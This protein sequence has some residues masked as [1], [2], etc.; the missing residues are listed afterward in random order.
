MSCSAIPEL[1]RRI[2]SGMDPKSVAGFSDIGQALIRGG[3]ATYAALGQCLSG[4]QKETGRYSA[5]RR[6]VL[7]APDP[8]S[9]GKMF[10]A[11]LL[12]QMAGKRAVI[13]M[14]MSKIAHGQKITTA[15]VVGT[16]AFP[17]LQTMVPPTRDL[18]EAETQHLNDLAQVLP[19]GVDYILLADRAYGHSRVQRQLESMGLKYVIRTRDK[20]KIRRTSS[21]DWCR[22]EEI[23][24]GSKDLQ[25]FGWVSFSKNDP[26]F[27]RVVR[28]WD[29]AH[30]EPLVLITN[31]DAPSCT[32]AR[33][34][35]CRFR[36]EGYFRDLK[37]T[38]Y[39]FHFGAKFSDDF[40][41]LERLLVLFNFA[42]LFME[43][44]GRHV[45]RRGWD[46]RYTK[47]ASRRLANWRLGRFF[48]ND[49]SKY[50]KSHLL[51]DTHLIAQLPELALRTGHWDWA[52]RPKEV[53][54]V[55][56]LVP[57]K[58]PTEK[59]KKLAERQCDKILRERIAQRL[60]HLG[61]GSGDLAR[62]VNRKTTFICSVIAG[63]KRV[64]PCLIEPIAHFLQLTP[65]DLLQDTGW[66][67]SVGRRKKA[68]K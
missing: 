50:A 12:E 31:L 6:M 19:R 35:A 40:E 66:T 54:Q 23:A 1:Y 7:K 42:Y 37:N 36:I 11:L 28:K 14:D 61:A 60:N 63:R 62:G 39:G 53:E 65:D 9:A 17:L 4:P 22:I 15:L 25:D 49:V 51:K 16:R 38:R 57:R 59:A 46:E 33:L 13:A 47:R 52:P 41:L 2:L 26:V 29:R 64:P 67:R 58:R 5:A 68:E 44:T 27:V 55:W 21:E 43:L 45:K 30:S 34:Y 56:V 24:F 18:V 3:Q 10:A 8:K 32:I 20:T 48:L